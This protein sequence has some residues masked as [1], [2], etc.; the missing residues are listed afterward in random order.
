MSFVQP[1]FCFFGI[2]FKSEY[3]IKHWADEAGEAYMSFEELCQNPRVIAMVTED[4]NA[5]GQGKFRSG[6][7]ASRQLVSAPWIANAYINT[8]LPLLAPHEKLASVVLIPGSFDQPTV[9][10]NTPWTIENRMLTRL[11][12]LNRKV[13]AEQFSSFLDS[14]KTR[15]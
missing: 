5:L 10:L 15:S 3:D 13:V 2:D 11:G 14:V 4:L 12:T 1:T 6:G 7:G 9:G 8:R